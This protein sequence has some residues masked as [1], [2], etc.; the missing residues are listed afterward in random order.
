MAVFPPI[1]GNLDI[2]VENTLLSDLAVSDLFS[3]NYLEFNIRH[4]T[5]IIQ[6][7]G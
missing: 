4:T 1:T 3:V 5:N 7:A 2:N 6:L